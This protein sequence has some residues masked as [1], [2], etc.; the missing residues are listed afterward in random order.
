MSI[1]FIDYLKTY[2]EFEEISIKEF[3]HNIDM[4]YT[5]LSQILSKKR[6]IS[7]DFI[8]K[9]ILVTPFTREDITKINDNYKLEKTIIE[10]IKEHNDTI[11]DYIERYN[12]KKLESFDN[13]IVLRNIKDE[14]QVVK[15]IMKYL[16]ITNP[17]LDKDVSIFF[18]SKC[19]KI[20]LVNIWLEKCFRITKTQTLNNYNKETSINNIVEYINTSAINYKFE[21]NELI[22]IFNYNGV[23]LAI[24]DDLPGSK[25]RGAFKVQSSKPAIYIT[26]KHKRQADIYFALL[27]ELAHLKSDFNKA[28]STALL[29]LIDT[30]NNQLNQIETIA[31]NKA[32]NWMVKLE[33]YQL[34]KNDLNNI[35]TY[36]NK[37]FLV[38]RLAKDNIISYSSD[39]YQKYN[40]LI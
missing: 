32:L 38:Y 3:A 11:H 24:A 16:R 6:D 12:Y 4:N 28:K 2:L 9:I 5:Q 25:I 29:S 22:Q 20:E 26:T 37:M 17:Y 10:S 18:K 15:D 31:D 30:G 1:N 33:D 23:Y 36:E 40:K 27:H 13:N 7:D 21:I 34:L 19:N 39:L 14:L 8:Q 35:E